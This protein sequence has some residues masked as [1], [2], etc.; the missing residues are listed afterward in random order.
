MYFTAR[1]GEMG[2]WKQRTGRP[3][4]LLIR[5]FLH[6]CRLPPDREPVIRLIFTCAVSFIQGSIKSS[7]KLNMRKW[8]CLRLLE[9]LVCT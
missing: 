9:Y 4:V 7:D 2:E 3:A 1:M 8:A 6:A 5:L